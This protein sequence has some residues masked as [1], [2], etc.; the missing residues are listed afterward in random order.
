MSAGTYLCNA[1][2]YSFLQGLQTR[3]W[4]A[5]SGFIHLPYLP[6]QV[7]DVLAEMN[8]RRSSDSAKREHLPS[9]DLATQVRAIELAIEETV[10]T[11]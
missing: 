3:G 10:A 2:M 6:Q 9:M 5:P 4:S 1:A 7:A 11:I 8:R